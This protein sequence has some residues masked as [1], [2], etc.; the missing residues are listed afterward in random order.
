MDARTWFVVGV[1]AGVSLFQLSTSACAQDVGVSPFV[2]TEVEPAR[3]DQQRIEPVKRRSLPA[4]Q[5]L[6]V[7]VITQP[8]L[9]SLGEPAIRV[10]KSPSLRSAPEA[11]I[12][13][14]PS[15]RSLMQPAR[16]PAIDETASDD[17]AEPE[18]RPTQQPEI[19]QHFPTTIR[20][21]VIPAKLK[22]TN[23]PKPE[24]SAKRSGG[25][26]PEDPASS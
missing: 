18:A 13:P 5:R 10:V 15:F 6:S 16:Q 8:R 2:V 12:I 17:S 22:S 1:V 11:Q 9:Q 26:N 19:K 25:T 4:A 24:R 21:R 14:G 20:R 23:E 3:L 7:E